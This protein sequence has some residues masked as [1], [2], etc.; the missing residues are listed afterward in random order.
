MIPN[1][2]QKFRLT[3]DLVAKRLVWIGVPPIY[4]T[5]LGLLFSL[6]AA[7]SYANRENILAAVF[8]I[9]GGTSDA[10]DGSIARVAGKITKVGGVLDST[11]DRVGDAMVFTGIIAG[12]YCREGVGLL[13]MMTA[14]LV[15]YIRG[16]AEVEGI[17]MEGVGIGERPERVL[18]L[19]IFTIF[20]RIPVSLIILIGVSIFTICQRIYHTFRTIRESNL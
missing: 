11:V 18:I 19:L 16:R 1:I 13:V 2:K 7:L 6:L 5:V 12:G 15:S 17:K 10:L 4:L 9:L 20:N 8:L 3:L 14:Y